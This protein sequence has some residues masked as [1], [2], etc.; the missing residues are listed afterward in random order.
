M[1]LDGPVRASACSRSGHFG[2][3]TLAPLLKIFSILPPVRIAAQNGHLE[4][5]QAFIEAGANVNLAEA[6]GSGLKR[7][8]GPIEKLEPKWLRSE[9]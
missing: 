4:I 8:I 9:R 1:L 2:M 6:N 3:A 7:V 5:V